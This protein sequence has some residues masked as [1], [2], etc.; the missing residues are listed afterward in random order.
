MRD[1]YEENVIQRIPFLCADG[2][3]TASESL[4]QPTGQVY[5]IYT[6]SFP[7]TL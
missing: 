1:N 4:N 6:S 3:S 2:W 7:D 5:V